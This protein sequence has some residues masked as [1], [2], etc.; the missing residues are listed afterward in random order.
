MAGEFRGNKSTSAN[1]GN[2]KRDYV[3]DST[4]GDVA[5]VR[6]SLALVP[7]RQWDPAQ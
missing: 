5:S 3:S 6:I 7:D 2:A 1:C 4:L